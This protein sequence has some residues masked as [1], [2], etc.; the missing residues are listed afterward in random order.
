MGADLLELARVPDE[1]GFDRSPVHRLFG[2][3]L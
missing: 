2:Q 3:Q 1:A